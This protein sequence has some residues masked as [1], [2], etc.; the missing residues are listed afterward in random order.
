MNNMYLLEL[1]YTLIPQPLWTSSVLFTYSS[2]MPVSTLS[3]NTKGL[4]HPAKR[5]SLWKTAQTHN[6][7]V[8]CV[9]EMHFCLSDKPSCQNQHLPHIFNACFT[10]KK[11]GDMVV[12]KDTVSFHL[13]HSILDPNGSFI[14]NNILYIVLN[15]FAPKKKHLAFLPKTIRNHNSTARALTNLRGLLLCKWAR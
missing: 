8:L 6:C 3:I 14:I 1:S 9:Q 7:E 12:I 10:T 2:I 11:R 5:S 15:I 13:H 4:N